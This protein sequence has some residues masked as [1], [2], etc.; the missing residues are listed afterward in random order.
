MPSEAEVEVS[1]DAAALAASTADRTLRMLHDAVE[2]RGTA[3]LV[4]T[5]GGIL[6]QVMRT[7][8]ASAERD[9]VDWS[10]VQLWWGDERFVAPDSPD[11]ND[12]A[13]FDALFDAVSLDPARVHRM[14]STESG[15]G[16]DVVAA[17]EGYATVLATAAAADGHP[18]EVPAFD[19]ILLGLGPDGHC[20]SL[21]PH[22]P[23]LDRDELVLGVTG[24]PKPPPVRISLGF[25]ALDAAREIWF[26]ASGAA[27][28]DAVARALAPDA[29]YHDV[30]SARPRGT[31]R[32]LWLID[33]DA[34]AVARVV[35]S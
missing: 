31:D 21:F 28:A 35:E 12:R 34:A 10:R 11:R 17:A 1:P 30:P 9:T 20:A 33:S 6:E 14:P 16:D 4:V 19:L 32:T 23:A 13:A 8:R 26:I 27:K 29:D 22:H 5:G 24:S 7:L 3:H 18:A 15:Y 25:G 2:Q